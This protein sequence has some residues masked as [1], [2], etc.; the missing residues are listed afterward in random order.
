MLCIS[1]AI[2]RI[3][4]AMLCTNGDRKVSLILA[5]PLSGTMI[6]LMK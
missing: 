2:Q 4:E 5:L 3:S 6:D 1:E